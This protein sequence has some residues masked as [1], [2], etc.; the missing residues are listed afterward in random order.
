VLPIAAVLII[1]MIG[2][3][4]LTIDGGRDYLIHRQAQNATDLAALA[5]GKQLAA[6]GSILGGPPSSGDLS[7]VAAHDFAGNNGF[8]T[9]YGNGCDSRT[10]TTFTATWFDV[11][12]LACSASAGYSTRVQVNSPPVPLPG[13][14]I[15]NQCSGSTQYNCFQVTITSRIPALPHRRPRHP[16]RLQHHLCGGLRPAA[17]ECVP[18]PTAACG[19]PLSTPGW[20]RPE[21]SAMLRRVKGSEPSG[22]GL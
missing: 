6:S 21:Q 19:L 17:R 15:P 11:T 10:P 1:V 8:S 9:I 16:D 12:G 20:L 14:S 13:L 22:A 7:V 4:G 18:H 2:I 3:A 5:A